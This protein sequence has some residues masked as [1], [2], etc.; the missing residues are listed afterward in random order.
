MHWC[1]GPGDTQY[2][3]LKFCSQSSSVSNRLTHI[4]AITL[5]EHMTSLYFKSMRMT[6]V[7][8]ERVVKKTFILPMSIKNK[9]RIK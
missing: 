4:D 2:L 3:G 6:Q 8:A 5:K 1:H 7:N 9:C